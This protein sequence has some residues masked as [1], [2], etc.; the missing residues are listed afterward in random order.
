MSNECTVNIVK[1]IKLSSLHFM[2]EKIFFKN[3]KAQ[4]MKGTYI[5]THKQFFVDGIQCLFKVL[6]D[7]V[8]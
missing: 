7:K 5:H 8:F 4:G 3:Q 6:T 1:L 2:A